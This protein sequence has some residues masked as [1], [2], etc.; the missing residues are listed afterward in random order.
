MQTH[1]LRARLFHILHKPSPDNRLARY[2]NYFLAFLILSNALSVALETVP[3][4]ASSYGSIFKDFEVISTALFVVEYIARIWV[5]VEQARYSSSVKGRIRYALNPLPLLDLI[6]IFTFLFTIDLRFLRIARLVRLLKVLKLD[7]FEKSLDGILAGL[8]KRR[9][10]II[11]SITLMI[12]CIYAFSALIYQLE[13]AAQPAVFSS[14][15]ATFWWAIETLTTIGYG[16][17]IPITMAGRFFA[18]LIFVFGIGVFALPMAIITAV[19]LEAGA[20]DSVTTSCRHCGRPMITLK[21][22]TPEYRQESS[23]DSS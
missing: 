15:P 23:G 20:S 3:S 4:L 7:N 8:R 19:I 1:H 12:L 18:G 6:V 21:S 10:L 11:V 22:S 16:D 5:C 17:M 14:I 9:E 13:H 2:A